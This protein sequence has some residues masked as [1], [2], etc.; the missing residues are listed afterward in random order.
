[1]LSLDAASWAS[2]TQRLTTLE[3]ALEQVLWGTG[4]AERG[5]Q[6]TLLSGP[7]RGRDSA[8]LP[9]HSPAL[10]DFLPGSNP[11]KPVTPGHGS[12][13]PTGPSIHPETP[14]HSQSRGWTLTT[15]A[16]QLWFSL[17]AIFDVSSA[18]GAAPA[19]VSCPSC[20]LPLPQ[21]PAPAPAPAPLHPNPGPAPTPA[22]AP[23][24]PLPR[25][26]PAQAQPQ[27]WPEATHQR[28]HER[29]WRRRGTLSTHGL[30]H[31]APMACSMVLCGGAG[32]RMWGRGQEEG[33]RCAPWDPTL[34]AGHYVGDLA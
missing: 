25:P 5:G 1:M 22:Q 23:P 28:P 21:L 30:L 13:P 14:G 11:P 26:S 15:G 8:R 20:L 10:A 17:Q 24:H 27:P 18:S 31:V 12:R 33:S 9:P 32:D 19:P 16:T 34:Q 3:A 2:F 7:P 6:D 29:S 4:H